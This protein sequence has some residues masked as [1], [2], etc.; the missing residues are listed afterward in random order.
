MSL[1]G[2]SHRHRTSPRLLAAAVTAVLVAGLTA[3]GGSDSP[4]PVAAHRPMDPLFRYQWHLVNTGQVGDPT[5]GASGVPGVDINVAPVWERGFDGSGVTVAVV[6][7][8]LEV[9]HEDLRVNVAQGL[10]HNYRTGDGDPTPAEKVTSHGTAVAGIIAA[11]RNGTGGIGVAPSAKL[12]GF[13]LLKSSYQS[14]TIDAL[15]RGVRN[16]SVAISNNSWGPVDDS[17]MPTSLNVMLEEVIRK[18]VDRGRAGKGIVYVFGAGNADKHA[19]RTDFSDF[20]SPLPSHYIPSN[21]QGSLAKQALPICAVNAKGVASLYSANG[22]NLLVCAPS[23]DFLPDTAGITTT[24]PFGQY[25]HAFGGTSAAAPVVSGVVALMLQANPNLTWR[26]VRLI[27]ART[28]RILPSM[29][30]DPGAEWIETGARNPHTGQPYRYSTRY[31]FGLVDAEAAVSYAQRFVSVGGS[32]QA[33]WEQSCAGAST[34]ASST[35]TVEQT[36][37]MQCGWRKVEFLDV[38]IGLEHP[39]FRALRVTLETPSGT[40]IVLSRDYSRCTLLFDPG[41]CSTENINH[42]FRTHA[43]TALDEPASGNWKLHIEDALGTGEPVRLR[44]A[45]LTIT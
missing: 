1:T 14:D 20:T 26:D 36:I 13:T 12:A 42:R 16:G 7:D 3:C 17:P 4:A 9:G 32:S 19:S 15:G 35:G 11:A 23:S 25:D 6:D 44:H 27:L 18:G 41:H 21:F 34:G 31:G 2:R 38:D 24:T 43:I 5:G 10:S 22:S 29:E 45:L 33:F 39:N 37:E 8:G 40:K 30:K 28:A